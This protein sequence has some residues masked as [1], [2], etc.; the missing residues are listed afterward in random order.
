MYIF[1]HFIDAGRAPKAADVVT[2]FGITEGA[3]LSAFR[4]LRDQRLVLLDRDDRDILMAHP[5]ASQNTGF[6][7]ATRDRHWW[8]GCSWEAFAIPSLVN[9]RCLVATHCPGC[10]RVLAL[11]VPATEPP[12]ENWVAHFLVPVRNMWR[13]V[14]FTCRHQVL[15]CNQQHLDDWLARS[16]FDQGAAMDLTTLWH[17]ATRWY[18]GRFGPGARARTPQ[19]ITAFFAELGLTDAFWHAG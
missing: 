2:E 6:V 14:L 12:A 5:F 11:D 16:G 19:E 4:Q 13:N 7:V 9:A 17:L 15:F 18:E 8:G 3:A 1:R 10:G